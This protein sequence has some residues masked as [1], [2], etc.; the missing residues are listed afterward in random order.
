MEK[1]VKD[2]VGKY[3][4]FTEQRL[5]VKKQFKRV[6][7]VDQSEIAKR[8]Q[9]AK[10]ESRRNLVPNRPLQMPSK[11]NKMFDLKKHI[12]GNVQQPQQFQTASQPITSAIGAA[13]AASA[14]S[15]TNINQKPAF[16]ASDL[17][18]GQFYPVVCS[19]FEDGP[20]KFWVQL[21]GSEHILDKMCSEIA[22]AP[23]KNLTNPMPGVACIARFSTDKMLYRAVIKTVQTNGCHVIFVDYGNSE[24]V[25]FPDIYEIPNQFLEHKTFAMQYQLAGVDQLGPMNQRLTEYFTALTENADLELKV[26]PSDNMHIRQVELHICHNNIFD[27]LMEKKN[28][29]TTYPMAEPL[30]NDDRVFIRY[31]H[32]AKRFFVQ[33]INDVKSFEGMMDRLFKHVTKAPGLET[34]PAKGTCCAAMVNDDAGEFYRAI[35]GDQIDKDSKINIFLVDY[36]YEAKVKK[37]DLRDLHPTFLELPRQ[38]IE[39]CLVDFENVPDVPTITAEQLEML[40][41]DHGKRTEFKVTVRNRLPSGLHI[42]DLRDETKEV[43]VSISIYKLAMPRKSYNNKRDSKDSCYTDKASKSYVSSDSSTSVRTV[44][45]RKTTQNG[46]RQCDGAE[47]QEKFV[48]MINDRPAVNGKMN[49]DASRLDRGSNQSNRSRN[50]GS[51]HNSRT[52]DQQKSSSNRYVKPMFTHLTSFFF[53]LLCSTL[54][55][56]AIHYPNSEILFVYVFVLIT[57]KI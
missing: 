7:D 16:I 41:D 8:I 47:S 42:V 12:S 46:G 5:E 10:R 34:F 2:Q 44:I 36:G 51:N 40:A 6:F 32:T 28:E 11:N 43:N 33:R 18:V 56:N 19:Y 55:S 20:N 50:S 52:S 24:F 29:F 26:V 57:K 35:V 25:T 14:A 38:A 48:E 45:D 9:P 23:R 37:S 39:C 31:T 49:G 4:D 15:T 27:M 13:T 53:F 21:K 30:K 54:N 17:T 3:I 22:N 1:L